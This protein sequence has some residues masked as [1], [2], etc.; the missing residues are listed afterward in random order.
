VPVLLGEGW[1]SVPAV[2]LWA[3]IGLTCSFPIYM[4]SAGYLFATDAG[5]TVL[6]TA[7]AGAA[8]WVTVALSLVTVVGAPAAGIGWCAAAAV[9]LAILIPRIT[10]R[11]GADVASSLAVPTT[12]A[13]VAAV[14]GWL[15]ADA[16]GGS[17]WGGLAGLAAGEL[18]LF[19][20]LG[21]LGRGALRDTRV[22]LGDAVGNFRARVFPRRAAVDRPVAAP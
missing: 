21:L 9:Q 11:S 10:A 12:T 19:A 8:A 2:L 20:V 14:G 22:I 15:V 6:K 18:A 7:V 4:A 3:G 17:L 13:V 1:E 16:S 5:G